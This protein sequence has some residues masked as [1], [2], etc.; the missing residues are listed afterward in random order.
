MDV[1]DSEV[2]FLLIQVKR[3]QDKSSKKSK[4]W[5]INE[6]RW[7]FDVCTNL[8]GPSTVRNIFSQ[9]QIFS[10]RVEYTIQKQKFITIFWIYCFA[11]FPDCM[12]FPLVDAN[13]SRLLKAQVLSNHD[14]TTDKKR[15]FFLSGYFF[16][17]IV[18][19]WNNAA[20][21]HI[22]RVRKII[23]WWILTECS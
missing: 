14:A 15:G 20:T 8:M 7:L 5:Y 1:R 19:F 6:W 2:N 21:G 4:R 18:Q 9:S 12:P 10:S 3:P 16:F 13:I 23:Q 17:C 22:S 11:S